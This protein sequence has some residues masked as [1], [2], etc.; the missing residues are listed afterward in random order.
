MTNLNENLKRILIIGIIFGGVFLSCEKPVEVELELIFEDQNH[1]AHSTEWSADSSKIYFI[2][3]NDQSW[4]ESEGPV[5]CLDL[6]RDSV[7]KIT[8]Q[9]IEDFEVSQSGNLAVTWQN[10][11]IQVGD[12]ATWNLI[13]TL[14]PSITYPIAQPKFSY[15]SDQIIY[16]TRFALGHGQSDTVFLHRSNLNDSTGMDL[17][18]SA[19]KNMVFAPG[20]GDTLFALDDTIFNLKNGEKIPLKVKAGC[21]HWNPAVPTELLILPE[22]FGNMNLYIFDL[23]TRKL[24]KLDASTESTNMNIEARFS[25]DGKIVVLAASNGGDAIFYN[26]IWL[27]KLPN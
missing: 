26:Q 10:Y 7:Y 18:S 19:G 14:K 25:P 15:E 12:L 3:G 17:L 8:D 13:D 6:E 11:W 4:Y 2:L 9:E 27:I 5:F 21:L 20:P 16:Y 23:N 24:R 22:E 1:P